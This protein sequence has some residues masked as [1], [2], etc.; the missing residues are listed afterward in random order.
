MLKQSMALNDWVFAS[1]FVMVR[2]PLIADYDAI[3]KWLHSLHYHSS[4]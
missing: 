4:R 2:P 1:L 3:K